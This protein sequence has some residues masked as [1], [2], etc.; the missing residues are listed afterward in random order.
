M[1]QPAASPAIDLPPH[2]PPE[3][4]LEWPLSPEVPS[5]DPF[6][7]I[8]PRIH[9]GPDIFYA[10]NGLAPGMPSWIFCRAEDI[11]NVFR[12]KEHFTSAG[13]PTL[14]HMLGET[15]NVIPVDTDGAEHAAYR[16]LLNPLFTPAR[17]AMLVDG[18]HELAR[19]LIGR[20]A[21]RGRCEFIGEFARPLPVTLFLQMMD[22][23]QERMSE[24]LE[25]EAAIISGT[26]MDKRQW[27]ITNIKAFLLNA[28]AER[29]ANP[30]PDLLSELMRGK[31]G[32]REPTEIEV[33]GMALNL[34]LGGLD[35][36]TSMAGWHFRHL[37]MNPEHQAELRAR[38]E[39]IPTALEELLRAYALVTM[40]RI[41]VK[42][43]TIR[44]V[45]I[46]PGDTVTVS[47]PIAGRDP[48]AYTS[49]NEIRLDRAPVHTAFAYGRHRCLGSHIARKE[50]A[51]M[52]EEFLSAIPPFRVEEGAQ[53]PMHLGAQMGLHALPLVWDV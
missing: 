49:P 5:E 2:V 13:R 14:S 23:P 37:A 30:G 16:A 21:A 29:R 46:M 18:A 9:E 36:I 40:N 24:F 6:T 35:T 11:R 31:V 44:G 12:D 28:I 43:V 26:G 50:L 20:F 33:F 32:E 19:E 3:L 53:V 4:A 22:F 17:A 10:V 38:P 47:T 48:H 52:L 34:F 41:C 45:T 51:V 27:A 1:S 42:Q 8:I 7:E 15:W 39:M 25:W